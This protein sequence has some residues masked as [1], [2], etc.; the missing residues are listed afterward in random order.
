MR[1]PRKARTGCRLRRR[2]CPRRKTRSLQV[3]STLPSWLF[4]GLTHRLPH[5]AAARGSPRSVTQRCPTRS[6]W[7]CITGD[8]TPDTWRASMPPRAV[9]RAVMATS[10]WISRL[11]VFGRGSSLCAPA[12]ITGER[13]GPNLA[14][15]RAAAKPK[16]GREQRAG[17]A[18]AQDLPRP[19]L[20]PGAGRARVRRALYEPGAPIREVVF[21]T[22]GVV[23]LLT[24]GDGRLALEVGLVGREGMVGV[25]LA[26]GIDVS[27]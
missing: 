6:L 16:A 21:P 24:L 9:P 7:R 1:R 8:I 20:G 4:L 10:A 19:A 12:Y 15:W 11:I 18:A 25:A 17:R 22:N 13:R 27:P 23:S 3:P 2:C 5:A 14:A 26:L